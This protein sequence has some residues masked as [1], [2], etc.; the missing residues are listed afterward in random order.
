VNVEILRLKC[1]DSIQLG[2]L[3]IQLQNCKR[4]GGQVMQRVAPLEPFRQTGAVDD[5]IFNE[6]NQHRSAS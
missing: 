2:L 1:L 6:N 4:Y 5:T 3:C